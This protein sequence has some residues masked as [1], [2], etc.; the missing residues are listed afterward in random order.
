MV[1]TGRTYCFLHWVQTGKFMN[2]KLLHNKG[3]ERWKKGY[4]VSTKPILRLDLSKGLP[5]YLLRFLRRALSRYHHYNQSITVSRRL[6][7][8][9]MCLD[10]TVDVL[11]MISSPLL[12]AWHIKLCCIV[13][14]V[15]TNFDV[16]WSYHLLCTYTGYILNFISESYWLCVW[17]FTPVIHFITYLIFWY[18]STFGDCFFAIYIWWV[19][20][21]PS[22]IETWLRLFSDH[23]KTYLNLGSH[24]RNCIF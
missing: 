12:F 23:W 14:V 21:G 7:T 11:P 19:N 4:C 13:W 22:V 24:F 1:F 5:K 8:Q 10:F 15:I 6:L 17:I 16:F 2:F 20:Y 3:I 18:S 9:S